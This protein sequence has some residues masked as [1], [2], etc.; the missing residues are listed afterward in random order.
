MSPDS[1]TV[2]TDDITLLYLA[3]QRFKRVCENV[4]YVVDLKGWI[5]MIKVHSNVMEFA[6]TISTRLVLMLIQ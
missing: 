3:K 6:A 4:R 5:W 2:R 1:M